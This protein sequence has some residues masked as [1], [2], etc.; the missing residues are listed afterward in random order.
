M[1]TPKFRIPEFDFIKCILI[2][3]VIWGH[4]CMYTSGENYDGNTLTH[5]IRLFQMPMFIMISGIFYKTPDNLTNAI[6]K[7]RNSLIHIGSPLVFWVIL[8]FISFIIIGYFTNCGSNIL[9][10]IRS[11][12]S[13]YWY[14]ICLLLCILYTILINLIHK[15]KIAIWLGGGALT[16]IPVNIYNW[17]FLYLFFI[18]GI[19]LS[20][21]KYQIIEFAK[22]SAFSTRLLF[23]FLVVILSFITT[24]EMTFYSR[25]NY[26]FNSP[27]LYNQFGLELTIPG[28]LFVFVRYLIY[29]FS[30]LVFFVLFCHLYQVL[31]KYK[32]NTI[33][34]NLGKET[35]F[36]FV[37]HLYILV[38]I[39]KILN[40]IRIDNTI[41]GEAPF[42]RFYCLDIILT[43]ILI[44]SL[45]F[46]D[47]LIDKN[48]S[49]TLHTLLLGK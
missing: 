34:I 1:S 9:G 20:E 23:L 13:I 30:T 44:V 6:K 31:S 24:N 27:F 46:T 38:T 8:T 21:Y 7:T 3:C 43:L 14:F 22:K 37:A 41:M 15:S 48:K 47:K 26:I 11:A 35:L 2:T 28:F 10:T 36:L 32:I 42:V 5:I 33:L 29:G 39:S 16:L 12:L 49:K 45:Y 4:V 19:S 25:T 40:D 17:N 18:L